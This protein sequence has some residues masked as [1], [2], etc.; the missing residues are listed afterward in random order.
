MPAPRAF[1][2]K[3]EIVLTV[4]VVGAAIAGCLWMLGK[5]R[6]GVAAHQIALA[7]HEHIVSARIDMLTAHTPWSIGHRRLAAREYASLVENARKD[8]ASGTYGLAIQALTECSTIASPDY[9]ARMQARIDEGPGE[10]KAARLAALERLRAACA[11]LGDASHQRAQLESL[12]KEAGQADDAYV[13]LR[14]SR[15]LLLDKR[16]DRAARQARVREL[17]Q[18]RDPMAMGVALD[19]IKGEGASLD[20]E[21]L[22]IFEALPYGLAWL[23]VMCDT[24]GE[25]H[26]PE[27]TMGLRDCVQHGE[28]GRVDVEAG[29]ARLVPWFLPEKVPAYYRRIQAHLERGRYDAFGVPQ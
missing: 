23:H 20:G 18:M 16:V 26:G 14:S 25:C 9:A 27:T 3:I 4:V 28:C 5:Q 19:G 2:R 13:R 29:I 12:W 6:A 22:S 21:A 17:M 15:A 1:S 7:R 8:P 10:K 24:F 11:P